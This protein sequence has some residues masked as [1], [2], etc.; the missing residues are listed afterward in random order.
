MLSAEDGSEVQP[1]SSIPS[2]GPNDGFYYGD[3]QPGLGHRTAAVTAGGDVV[4]MSKQSLPVVGFPQGY[5]S[6]GADEVYEF[7][8]ATDQLFCVSCSSTGEPVAWR[9]GGVLADQLE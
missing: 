8:A 2:L 4:F 1:F 9:R 5:P 3:W 7:Q 6:G